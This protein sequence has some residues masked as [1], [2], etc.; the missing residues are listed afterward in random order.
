MNELISKA[1]MHLSKG[2][3][4]H[5]LS[6]YQA[7]LDIESAEKAELAEAYRF[8]AGWHQA[9]G[10]LDEAETH[11]A[12]STELKPDSD[13]VHFELGTCQERRG[14][15]NNAL[16]SYL[17]ALK[18]HPRNAR[19]YLYAGYVLDELDRHEE[20]LQLWSIGSDIDLILQYAHRQNG[21]S[22][23]IKVRS[24][25]ADVALREHFT[26]LHTASVSD[27]IPR[28]K[29]A[30]WAQTNPTPVEFKRPDQKPQF[31][32][33]SDLPA[34]PVFENLD[35]M[36]G[37]EASWEDIRD[38]YLAAQNE[39]SSS[40]YLNGIPVSGEKWE[41]LKTNN[42][43][44][45]VHLYKEAVLQDGI[46]E[47][48]PETLAAL[49][50]V[51]VVKVNGEPLVAFFSVLSA[52]THIPPHYG[53]ANTRL[54]VHLPLIVPPECAVRV[55]DQVCHHQPGKIIAFDDSFEH[56]AWNRSDETR[57]VLIFEAWVP[58]LSEGEREAIST[59][60]EARKAW[61]AARKIPEM[62]A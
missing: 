15:L 7:L 29:N 46:E 26:Q 40:P 30:V 60:F 21:I 31:F 10:R 6:A 49:K 43:W 20:A 51:P 47:R 17:T 53:L 12:K 57:V 45:S 9:E 18:I 44:T 3:R 35:W 14:D 4:T 48:F 52:G 8:V 36:A 32:Y 23:E 41:A 50:K 1:R 54:T 5:A 24:L 59:A 58:D 25:R 27:E 38:E 39:V 16:H 56:E 33:I 55:S 61:L 34:I 28:V 19:H 22:E 62:P 2:Q 11:Y 13:F 37:M 42:T